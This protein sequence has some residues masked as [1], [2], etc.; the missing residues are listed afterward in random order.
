MVQTGELEQIAP[1]YYL[2]PGELDDTSAAW[3]SISL[4]KPAATVCLLSALSVP[5]LT[6]E[7][8]RAT[9]IALPRGERHLVARFQTRIQIHNPSVGVS[10]HHP[11]SQLANDYSAPTSDTHRSP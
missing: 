2:Q 6:D 1:G 8:P 3:A 10:L 9:D 11:R 5:D 4:R 7:I